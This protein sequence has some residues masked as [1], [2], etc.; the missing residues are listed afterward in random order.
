MPKSKNYRHSYIGETAQ[1]IIVHT[2]VYTGKDSQFFQH[3]SSTKHPRAKEA[4]FEV[5]AAKVI[6]NQKTVE[7]FNLNTGTK[8][9]KFQPTPFYTPKYDMQQVMQKIVPLMTNK[10]FTQRI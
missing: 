9:T 10:V 4:N 3:S 5:L 6:G 1:I 8:S 7:L 2:G